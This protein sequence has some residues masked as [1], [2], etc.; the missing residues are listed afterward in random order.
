MWFQPPDILSGSEGPVL[1]CDFQA[2]LEAAWAL[3]VER[4]RKK[5]CNCF[6][7]CKPVGRLWFGLRER[8]VV[9]SAA[10][11]DIIHTCLPNTTNSCLTS[12]PSP[13]TFYSDGKETRPLA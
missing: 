6:N 7:S 13:Y 12:T 8:R 11:T 4:G 9:K 3:A 1:S 2:C 10:S 5:G